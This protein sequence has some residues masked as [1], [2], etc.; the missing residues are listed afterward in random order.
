M[1]AAELSC[2]LNTMLFKSREVN[3]ATKR[4][5]ATGVRREMLIADGIREPLL[6]RPCQLTLLSC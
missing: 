5:A 1:S 2:L 3:L 4:N 6:S